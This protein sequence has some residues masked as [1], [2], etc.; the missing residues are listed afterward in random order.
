MTDGGVRASRLRDSD[1]VLRIRRRRAPAAAAPRG[2]RGFAVA[3]GADW[4]NRGLAA[5]APHQRAAS[6]WW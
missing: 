2:R 6:G 1:I 5:V 3:G 4:Y